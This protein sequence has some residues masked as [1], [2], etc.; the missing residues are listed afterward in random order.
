MGCEASK[1]ARHM[2]MGD[3]F[4][5]KYGSHWFSSF[6]KLE[7]LSDAQ[8]K[9]ELD[10]TLTVSS[11]VAS[12][13]VDENIYDKMFPSFSVNKVY[14]RLHTFVS[15]F[16]YD[17]VSTNIHCNS[18][19]T[20]AAV[21]LVGSKSWLIYPIEI[22]LGKDYL[23]SKPAR[24]THFPTHS[25]R[26]PYYFH[27]YTSRPGDILFFTEA[28]GH[29]VYS[30]QGPNYMVNY[31]KLPE[32]ANLMY[33]PLAWLHSFGFFIFSTGLETAAKPDIVNKAMALLAP[34]CEGRVSDWDQAMLDRFHQMK[35][36]ADF[37]K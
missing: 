3:I 31:R 9:K 16:D 15:N 27:E 11:T 7:V 4:G 25:P 12:S 6:T 32:L 29:S 21:Q 26:V 28:Y 20:S 33:N 13:V 19:A 1:K 23:E 22:Y 5:R 24:L 30:H 34:T 35:S 10:D 17:R 37:G 18:F 14:D 8:K 36:G 2:T